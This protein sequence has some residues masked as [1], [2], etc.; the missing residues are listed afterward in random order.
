MMEIASPIVFS[1]AS[2]PYLSTSA[3]SLG[4][5]VKQPAPPIQPPVQAIP[6]MKLPS[7]IFIWTKFS[8]YEFWKYYNI[9][10]CNFQAHFVAIKYSSFNFPNL[11]YSIAILGGLIEYFYGTSHAHIKDLLESVVLFNDSRESVVF[12][13]IPD[14]VTTKKATP[15]GWRFIYPKQIWSSLL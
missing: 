5:C 12:F 10:S 8:Y 11:F 14:K 13:I 2:L 9:F 3:L 4:P 7:K 15:L 1:K 6:S